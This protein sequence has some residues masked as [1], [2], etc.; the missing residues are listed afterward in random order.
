MPLHTQ[1][2]LDPVFE[3]LDHSHLHPAPAVLSIPSICRPSVLQ[4]NISSANQRA[5]SLALYSPATAPTNFSDPDAFQELTSTIIEEL[6]PTSPIPT[7]AAQFEH[8]LQQYARKIGFLGDVH[9]RNALLSFL[10]TALQTH[11]I[12]AQR[13]HRKQIDVKQHAT[14][15]EQFAQNLS[16]LCIA[17]A[18][19][20]TNAENLHQPS[21]IAQLIASMHGASPSRIDTSRLGEPLLAT[22]LTASQMQL[23]RQ[24]ARQL[25]REHQLRK[26]LLLNRLFVTIESFRYSVLA[27]KSQSRI[28]AIKRTVERYVDAQNPITL[29]DAITA[30]EYMLRSPRISG[31]RQQIG[32][33]VQPEAAVKTILMGAVP[34]RGGRV[35]KAAMGDMPAFT[36]RVEGGKPVRTKGRDEKATQRKGKGGRKR[37]GR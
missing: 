29:Y 3:Q 21:Q 31:S 25:R 2:N 9:D 13:R 22:P 34:D 8:A 14:P 19:P 7:S 27:Q 4:M 16:R 26:G 32:A 18:T 5:I 23:A 20:V 37:R 1:H 36:D 24:T 10:L 11:R 6:D 35:G 15:D 17:T 33:N 30:R 28:S 12:L